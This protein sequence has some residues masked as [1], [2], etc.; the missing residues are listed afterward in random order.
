MYAHLIVAGAALACLLAAVSFWRQI[1]IK[2]SRSARLAPERPPAIGESAA[3]LGLPEVSKEL[4]ELWTAAR[5]S[6]CGEP[7]DSLAILDAIGSDRRFV[8]YRRLLESAARDGFPVMLREGM[9]LRG[10]HVRRDSWTEMTPHIAATLELA[11]E[12]A[13]RRLTPATSADV[14]D[15]LAVIPGSLAHTILGRLGY[16][17]CEAARQAWH[18]LQRGEKLFWREHYERTLGRFEARSSARLAAGVRSAREAAARR[19]SVTPSTQ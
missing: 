8:A 16:V 2:R 7:V 13:H 5:A 14:L 15:G 12:I 6:S 11:I 3:Y 19:S 1:T 10:S 9:P 18:H 4:R 17:P